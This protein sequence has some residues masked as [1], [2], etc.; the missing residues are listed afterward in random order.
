MAPYLVSLSH[1]AVEQRAEVIAAG[2]E[3][4]LVCRDALPL[5]YQ[6]HVR[7]LRREAQRAYM[8]GQVAYQ[9]SGK[10]SKYKT[11]FNSIQFKLK[12]FIIRMGVNI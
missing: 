3:D 9:Q 10:L 7:V 5:H 6:G 11:K 4:D 8:L 12:S 2:R 1:A